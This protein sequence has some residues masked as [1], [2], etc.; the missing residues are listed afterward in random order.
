MLLLEDR[1]HIENAIDI[2]VR[3]RVPADGGLECPL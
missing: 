3:W 2:R 1:P